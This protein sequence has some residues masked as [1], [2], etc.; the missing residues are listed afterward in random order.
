[1]YIIYNMNIFNILIIILIILFF[2]LFYII[3]KK[4]INHIVKYEVTKYNTN[5]E[6]ELLENKESLC[7]EFHNRSIKYDLCKECEKKNKCFDYDN[8]ICTDCTK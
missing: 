6:S 5:I 8:N 4:S 2:I 1:M 3:F 7:S